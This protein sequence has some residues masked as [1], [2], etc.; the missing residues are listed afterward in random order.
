MSI[1]DG[2]DSTEHCI[3]LLAQLETDD[4]I[5]R[6]F[7]I[8]QIREKLWDVRN[9]LATSVVWITD[10]PKSERLTSPPKQELLTGMKFKEKL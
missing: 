5:H 8:N 10:V 6:D 3:D 9:L 4:A 2:I 7:V 1:Q